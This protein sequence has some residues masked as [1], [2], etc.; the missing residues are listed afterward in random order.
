MH[1]QTIFM[2][3]RVPRRCKWCF[4]LYIGGSK[5]GYSHCCGG[6]SINSYRDGDYI[7]IKNGKYYWALYFEGTNSVRKLKN[8]LV[9]VYICNLKIEQ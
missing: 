2:S 5:G 1:L 6:S 9:S 8:I 4:L 3:E 7:Y